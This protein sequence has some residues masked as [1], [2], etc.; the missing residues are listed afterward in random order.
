MELLP[1]VG[2]DPQ[3]QA[4]FPCSLIVELIESKHYM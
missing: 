3:A 4:K 2:T 1:S